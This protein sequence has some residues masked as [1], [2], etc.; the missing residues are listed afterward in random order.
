MKTWEL[1]A[2]GR[3]QGVGFRWFVQRTAIQHG[4]NGYV[5]NRADGS[6]YILAQG[7]AHLLESFRTAMETGNRLARVEN[8]ET[9]ELDSAKKYD[10][11]EIR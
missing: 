11:F 1:I 9:T 6:V 5:K 3:V 10:D 2:R 4:L 7:E 8:V